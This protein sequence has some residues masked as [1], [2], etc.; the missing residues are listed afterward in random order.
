MNL[1]IHTGGVFQTNG[2]IL[3]NDDGTC[4][5][6]D[7][8]AEIAGFLAQNSL[9]PT[10]LLLTHQHLDHIEDAA[11]LREAGAK[12]VAFQ[13]YA[14]EIIMEKRLQEMGLPVQAIPFE[15][16]EVIGAGP[17]YKIAG[18]TFE[19][20]HVPGHSPDSISFHLPAESFLFAGDALFN[21]SIGRTDLPGGNHEQLLDSIRQNLYCLPDETAVLPGHGPRTSIGREKQSNPFCPNT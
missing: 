6:I 18:H 9:T 20:A 11:K 7:A 10:H 14:P 1:L 19:I 16:D 21:G 12:V 2:Y 17:T 13:D 15:V 3:A 8:P 4:I 5:V